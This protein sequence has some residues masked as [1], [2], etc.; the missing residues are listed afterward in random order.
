MSRKQQSS[1][2][3]ACADDADD[4]IWGVDGEH[5]I[6]AVLK[7]RP[8]QVY[9]LIRRGRLPVRK[10]GHR[11]ICANRKRSLEYCAGELPA[12]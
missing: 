4:L 7:L 12:A 11:T 9:Y 6:A 1:S 3:A 8:S 10:F 2:A 5:G